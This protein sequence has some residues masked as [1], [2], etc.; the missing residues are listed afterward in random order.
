MSSTMI[1]ALVFSTKPRLTSSDHRK[2]CTGS[3]VDGEQMPPAHRD[4]RAHADEQQGCGLAQRTC[5]ADDRAG[6]DAGQR[7]RQDVVEHDLH[8]LAPTPSA[9]SRIDGGTA[10]IALRLAMTITGIDHQRERQP[11]TSGARA[12]QRPNQLMNTAR[13]SRPKMIDGTAA[14]LLIDTSIRSVQRFFGAYSSR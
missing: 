10:L 3:T 1:A 11:P 2:I 9:A 5:H 4:E 8:R 13:P 14:R 12:G 6:Q 7:E